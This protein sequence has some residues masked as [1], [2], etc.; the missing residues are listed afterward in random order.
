MSYGAY[1]MDFTE[2]NV[3]F[4]L[5]TGVKIPSGAE[6]GFFKAANQLLDDA[7]NKQ[8]FAPF[9][10]GDLRGSAR[11]D[12]AVVA[13]SLIS[14]MCGFNISYAA[15]WHELTPA[16]DARINWTLPGSGAKYLESKMARY[17]ADYMEIV[18]SH[19]RNSA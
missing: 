4:P 17:M 7:I 12:K 15:R 5:V 10:K 1:R 6:E 19:I 13:G 8:P 16:E 9:D 2:F 14:V 3:K 11:V 18:A